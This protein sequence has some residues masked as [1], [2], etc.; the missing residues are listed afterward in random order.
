MF[1]DPAKARDLPVA[2]P[3]GKSI[4]STPNVTERVLL[5]L[6]KRSKAERDA[7]LTAGEIGGILWQARKGRISSVNGGGDYAAQM[8]LG[9]MRKSGL[10]RVHPRSITSV[11][12]LTPEGKERALR[13]ARDHGGV[14]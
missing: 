3:T 8:L 2:P 5:A 10:V 12:I 7:G 11:W 13:A 6:L 4:R 1:R 14:A 9:R